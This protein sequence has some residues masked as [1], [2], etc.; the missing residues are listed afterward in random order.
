MSIDGTPGAAESGHGANGWVGLPKNCT[1][2]LIKGSFGLDDDERTFT[3]EWVGFRTEG[4]KVL[5]QHANTTLVWLPG[6]P[7]GPGADEQAQA[8][9]QRAFFNRN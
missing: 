6:G 8:E 5:R 3:G 2:V 9:A 1:V 7:A 4:S